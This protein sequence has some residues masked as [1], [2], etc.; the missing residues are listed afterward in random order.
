MEAPAPKD[1]LLAPLPE[2]SS[3]KGDARVSRWLREAATATWVPVYISRACDQTG[4]SE[5]E[6]N[7]LGLFFPEYSRAR[8]MALPASCDVC[9]RY[10]EF[11]YAAGDG[12]TSPECPRFSSSVLAFPRCP[13]G[14]LMYKPLL[15][16]APP[17]SSV[18]AQRRR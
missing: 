8:A 5:K 7:L 18:R 17:T 16:V 4:G 14:G 13:R 1:Y 2:S 12:W 3:L 15:P 10:V 6:R 11:G 9:R